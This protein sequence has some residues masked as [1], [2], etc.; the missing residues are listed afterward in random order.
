MTPGSVFND[1]I[2]ARRPVLTRTLAARVSSQSRIDPQVLDERFVKI[3]G[4][5][6]RYLVCGAGKPLVLCHGFLSSAEEFGG[7]FSELGA[8]RLLIIPDLPGNGESPPLRG[9]HSSAAMADLV[10]DLLTELEIDRFDVG[11]LCLGATVACALTKRA[12]DRVDRLVLHTPLLSPDLM[13]R[14]YREQ[15]RLLCRRPM[16]DAVV[17]LSRQR[18]ISDLYKRFVIVEGDVDNRTADVN[19]ENQRRADPRAAREWL[20]DCLRRDDVD[21]VAA[22]AAA[23]LIIVARHDR[24]VDVERL[25]CL[26]AKLPDLNVFTDS[27]QGHGWNE[28]AVHRQLQV[29]QDFFNGGETDG[30]NGSNRHHGANGHNGHHGANG[31][32]GNGAGGVSGA[33]APSLRDTVKVTISPI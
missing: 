17:W 13:R 7:R 28:A 11:G 24:L 21:V 30:H 2:D 32:N 26:I 23:T 14:R 5:T 15:V 16:W 18:W 33:A 6:L 12:G 20:N 10:F 1:A 8:H 22:R 25:K 4:Q 29:L 27:D 3:R 31:H 19:Y 9:R